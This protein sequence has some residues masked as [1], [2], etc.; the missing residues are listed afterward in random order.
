MDPVALISVLRGVDR[1][2]SDKI[3]CCILDVFEWFNRKQV[4]Q[5]KYKTN[6]LTFDIYGSCLSFK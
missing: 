5:L 3:V 2:V 6:T 1:Y 4:L